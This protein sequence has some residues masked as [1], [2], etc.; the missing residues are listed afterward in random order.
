MDKYWINSKGENLGPFTR[1]EIS[2]KVEA[3]EFVLSDPI[4]LVGNE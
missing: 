1:E 2:E 3:G 4:C